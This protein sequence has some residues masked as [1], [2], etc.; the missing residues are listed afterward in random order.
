MPKIW[1][2]VDKEWAEV[3]K[4]RLVLFTVG[5]MPILFTA[6]P[7]LMVAIGGSQADLGGD[8]TDIPAQF[9]EMCGDLTGTACFTLMMVNQF[10][11]LF[12]ML[13][14]IIPITIAAYSIVGEKTTRCLEPLLATPITTAELLIGKSL[15]ALIPGVLATWLSFGVF[16][17]IAYI[18]VQSPELLRRILDPMWITAITLV[19]PLL[20]LAGINVTLMVSSR[21]SDPRTAEQASMMLVLPLLGIFFAQ[22]AGVLL[23]NA[24][25]MQLAAVILLAIDA[26]LVSLGVRVFQREAILTKWK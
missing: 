22:I 25:V 8:A 26:G 4:N 14:L 1:T 18:M 5:F 10:L 23:V 9:M 11:L 16:A 2:I 15:A 3:F 6:L 17:V 20:A 12:M 19:G 13:P 21:V 7:L 24:Q